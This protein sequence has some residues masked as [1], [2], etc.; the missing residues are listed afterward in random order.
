MKE[1]IALYARTSSE[2]EKDSSEMTIDSQVKA[3]KKS[4]PSVKHKYLDPNVSGTLP[5]RRRPG[6]RKMF[7]DAE[8]GLFNVVAFHNPTRIARKAGIHIFVIDRLKALGI[9]VEFVGQSNEDTPAGRLLLNQQAGFSE[10][11]REIIVD[12]LARGRRNKLDNGKF[13]GCKAPFGYNYLKEKGELV[14]NKDEEKK[15]KLIYDLFLEKRVVHQVAKELSKRRLRARATNNWHHNQVRTILTKEVYIGNFHFNRLQSVTDEETGKVKTTIRPREE[16]IIIKVPK[17]IDEKVFK[18]VQKILKN[19]TLKYQKKTKHFYLLQGL[20]RCGNCGWRYGGHLAGSGYV[21]YSCNKSHFAN[22]YGDGKCC[23]RYVSVGKLDKLIWDKIKDIANDPNVIKEYIGE[24]VKILNKDSE[25]AEET[26]KKLETKIEGLKIKKERYREMYADDQMPKG[27]AY[28][29]IDE[30]KAEEDNL[31]SSIRDTKE[32]L[33]QVLNAPKTIKEVEMFCELAKKRIGNFDD[34]QKKE[35]ANLVVKEIV[36]TREKETDP[37][38][39]L[40]NFRI[41]QLNS[42]IGEEK[43][44]LKLYFWEI[45]LDFLIN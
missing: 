18:Q 14:V 13:L 44:F 10:Y 24:Q 4:F 3:I 36:I 7:E 2:K 32:N 1:I 34:K 12:R 43:V 27:E 25:L 5:P 20:I 26:I 16:W 29:K 35:F 9:K 11:E 30:L 22:V 37:A 41:P 21:S 39:I 17:I 15:V 38:Q 23:N 31:N 8:K 28:K 45:D 19:N 42:V 33:G 40:I 6:M